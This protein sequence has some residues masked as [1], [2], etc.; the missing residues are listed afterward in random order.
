M[1]TITAEAISINI[2]RSIC[3][4]IDYLYHHQYPNGEFCVY[5]SGDD[6]MEGWNQADN[7]IFPSVLTGSCL[8]FLKAYP[9]V[10]EIL[11]KTASF[12]RSQVGY[13]GTWNHYTNQHAL[14]KLC[15]QDTDDTACTSDFLIKCNIDIFKKQN[16]ALLLHNRRRDGLFY[17]WFAFRFQFSFDT[18]YRR[19]VLKEFLHPVKSIFFWNKMECSRHDVDAVVNA[20]ILYYLGNMKETQPIIDLL[21]KTITEQKE[22]ECDKWYRNRF[23]VY[24]F[25]SRNYYKNIVRLQPIKEPITERILLKKN[26]QGGFGE[27]ILD[28]ALAICSL[29]NLDYKGTELDKAIEYILKGQ[30]ETGEWEKRRFY[31]GGPKQIVGFGSEELTTAFCLEALERYKAMKE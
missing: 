24:Y 4:G 12:L 19:L 17:T 27:S 30:K 18:S 7:C 11:T 2:D 16:A 6:A 29:L 14:R 1:N 20:N 13:G 5:M 22:N 10:E 23:T 8:L 9:R 25:F 15:P 3:A 21:I 26:N 28:T 31:Y